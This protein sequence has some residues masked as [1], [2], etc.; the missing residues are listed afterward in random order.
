MA[1]ETSAFKGRFLSLISRKFLL[2]LIA[3][4]IVGYKILGQAGGTEWGWILLAIITGHAVGNV[5][6]AN[7]TGKSAGG[8]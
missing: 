1:T 2:S 3:E 5:A 4:G 6:A 8:K 7:V